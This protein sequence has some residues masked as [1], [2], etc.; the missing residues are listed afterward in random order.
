LNHHFSDD[1]RPDPA[2]AGQFPAGMVDEKV[3][4]P[5]QIRKLAGKVKNRK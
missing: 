3:L 1:S 4:T 5:A 2:T